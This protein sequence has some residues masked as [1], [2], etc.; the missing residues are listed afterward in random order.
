M[1]YPRTMKKVIVFLLLNACVMVVGMSQNVA[2]SVRIYFHSGSSRMIPDSDNTLQVFLEKVHKCAVDGS[3]ERLLVRAYTSPDGVSTA[4]LQL[5]ADRCQSVSDYIMT[6]LGIDV[7]RIDILPG[8]IAWEELR[9]M[10]AADSR[11]PG[12]QETLDI[13]DYTP[14]WVRDA[15]GK[16]TGSRKKSLMDFQGGQTYRWLRQHFFD[17][18]HSATVVLCVKEKGKSSCG[19]I[20]QFSQALHRD[21]VRIFTYI[22]DSVVVGS[23]Q[24]SDFPVVRSTQADKS[25][26]VEVSQTDVLFDTNILVSQEPTLQVGPVEGRG[27]KFPLLKND[28]QPVTNGFVFKTNLLYAAALLPSIELE[29]KLNNYWTMSVE[30]N[31]AWWKRR[32]EHKC[33]QLAV[34]SSTVRRWFRCKSPRKKFYVGTFAG[35]GLYDFEN[36][37]KG[38]RGEGVFAGASIGYLYSVSKRLAIE[39]EGGGGWMMTRYKEYIPYEEH[40]LYIR[41]QNM[42]FFGPLRLKLAFVWLLGKTA[43]CT[44]KEGGGK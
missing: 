43:C 36:G 1:L 15:H 44:K 8:G 16:I 34:A 22:V 7:A 2:D 20:P 42:N 23:L 21:T 41:T 30:G 39:V 17:R 38:Y 24:V 4:N 26:T 32:E 3:L 18:L 28:R 19:N 40:H 35:A 14:I 31:V 12:R 27:G 25:T 13:I 37:K 5:S 6:H 33:Y 11:V 29:W 9:R 10:I